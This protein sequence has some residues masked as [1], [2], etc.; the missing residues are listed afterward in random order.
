MFV[1]FL[2]HDSNLDSTRQI[3]SLCPT[4]GKQHAE[5]LNGN[6]PRY[7]Q[8]PSG[9]SL[10]VSFVGTLPFITY[11]PIGGRDLMVIAVLAKKFRF[12]P[13]LIPMASFDGEA[14]HVSNHYLIYS[15]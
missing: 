1:S 10:P 12:L 5:L 2:L 7:L 14:N 6:C 4:L 9:K 13:N 3:L 8:H 15:T 11:N